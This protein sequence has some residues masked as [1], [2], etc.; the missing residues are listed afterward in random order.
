MMRTTRN[1]LVAVSLLLLS[2]TTATAQCGDWDRSIGQPGL[3]GG[4]VQALAVL[5]GAD[6][7]TVFAGG[8]FTMAGGLPA[9][10][11]ARWD[12]LQ[13]QALADQVEGTVHTLAVFDDGAGQALFVGGEFT[14]IDGLPAANIAK[15]DGFGWSVVGGGLDGQVFV[16]E[17]LDL[18]SGPVLY[19]GGRDLMGD[20]EIAMWDG[21]AWRALPSERSGWVYAMRAFDDGSGLSLYA[22]GEFDFSAGERFR[23]IARWDGSRWWPVGDGFDQRVLTLEVF[24]EGR[25]DGPQL[26]AGGAF[27]QSGGEAMGH[28]ARW[29]GGGW[30]SVGGG[31]SGTPGFELVTD[32]VLFPDASGSSL[33]IGGAFSEAGGVP[34]SNAARWNGSRWRSLGTGTSATVAAVARADDAAGPG[35]VLGGF[36]ARAGDEASRGAARWRCSWAF[37]TRSALA[38]ATGTIQPG[39]PRSGSSGD[40]FMNIQGTASGGGSFDSYAVARWDISTARAE[41]DSLFPG[42]WE[43]SDVELA[44]TQSNATFTNEGF[45]R[46]FVSSDD[47]T[48]AKSAASPLA[49]PFFDPVGGA[50]DLALLSDTPILEYFFLPVFTGWVDRYTT[51][52]GP[53]GPSEAIRLTPELASKLE[54]TNALTLVFVDDDPFVAATY[55]G[56]TPASG[57][58]PPTL[59]LT[60]RGLE[61]PCRPDLDGDGVLSLFD[62]LAFQN[63]FDTG[64]LQADFDGDGSLTI[65][66]FLAF[67]NAFDAGCP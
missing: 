36:F 34:A 58:Q 38:S 4:F 51:F 50:A 63:M 21:S 40:A 37:D 41:F 45:L 17:V 24:D 66:D 10:Q 16:L 19:A 12:G 29:D 49:Y 65:F 6:G 35:L 22:G 20:D 23:Y 53:G 2:A 27:T 15:W 52:G 67:Q 18:G 7:P 59:M 25:G 55:R 48:D 31:V 9:G 62:F 5:E 3:E 54:Q 33:V 57:R 43:I 64:D 28:I 39:G 14:S 32:M 56:Q 47:T 61:A 44:L 8:S 11:L 42:G 1:G 13:W 30:R 60:A 26:F 46:V